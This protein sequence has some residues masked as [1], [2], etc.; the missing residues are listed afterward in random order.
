M[1]RFPDMH[2]HMSASEAF[3]LHEMVHPVF[4]NAASADDFDAVYKAADS[5]DIFPFFGIHPWYADKESV[6]EGIHI[7][8]L[9]VMLEK[10]EACGIGE[11]GLDFSGERKANFDIQLTTFKTQLSLS[12]DFH[13]TL[14]IHCVRAWGPMLEIL[15]HYS[16]L[17]SPFILHSF[18][19][20][21]EVLSRL[22][23]LGAYISLSALSLRNPQRT[24]SVI[25]S[26][27]SDRILVES[28][29]QVG[30]ADYSDEKHFN[31]LRNNYKTIADIR[32]VTETELIAGVIENGQVFTD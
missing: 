18:Y 23:K 8:A 10:A 6:P 3:K 1:L 31:I 25:K 4:L 32:S 20:S 12:F 17:P 19:G 11:C 5:P 14:S 16:P 9:K 24:T 28:D 15:R 22:L 21:E 29:L 2:L 13:R 26:I 27:P 30:G 7:E